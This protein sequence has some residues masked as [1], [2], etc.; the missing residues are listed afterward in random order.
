MK[1]VISGAIMLAMLTP[2]YAQDTIVLEPPV[3]RTKPAHPLW[4]TFGAS[5]VGTGVIIA[6]RQGEE[7]YF[8]GQPYCVTGDD[9]T[10]R[11]PGPCRYDKNALRAGIG[12]AAGGVI[13]MLFGFRRV[14]VTPIA[15]PEAVGAV[16]VVRW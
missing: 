13:L 16:A 1:R 10:T 15:E 3:H 7:K 6:L 8:Q 12:T 14:T 11:T 5:L 2:V 4:G 9:G